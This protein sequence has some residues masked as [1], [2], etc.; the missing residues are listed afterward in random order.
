[1][2]GGGGASCKASF[3]LLVRLDLLIEKLAIYTPF[4]VLLPSD[5]SCFLSLHLGMVATDLFLPFFVP[6]LLSPPVLIPEMEL[7]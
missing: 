1:V 7:I 6:L 4:R 2:C 5:S 3:L